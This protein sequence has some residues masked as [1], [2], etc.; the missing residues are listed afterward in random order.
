ML[1]SEKVQI[2]YKYL[3]S[4]VLKSKQKEKRKYKNISQK[5]K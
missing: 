3:F 4:K 2:H 5:I 1:S